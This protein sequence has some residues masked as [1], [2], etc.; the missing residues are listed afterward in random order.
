MRNTYHHVKPCTNKK[1]HLTNTSNPVYCE[2]HQERLKRTYFTEVCVSTSRNEIHLPCH[3]IKIE[4]DLI[5]LT[6][7]SA[8]LI[9]TIAYRHRL[10]RLYIYIIWNFIESINSKVISACQRIACRDG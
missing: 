10:Y 1:I 7:N 6:D 3:D 4:T 5:D 8:K 2:N 9:T